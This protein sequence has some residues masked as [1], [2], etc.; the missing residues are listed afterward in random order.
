M[1]DRLP[2]GG[3]DS[4]SPPSIRPPFSSNTSGIVPSNTPVAEMLT[5]PSRWMNSARF[6]PFDFEHEAAGFSG[7]D[8]EIERPL[9]V[10]VPPMNGQVRP[11]PPAARR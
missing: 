9:A 3:L 6:E 11:R 4:S 10:S 8:V 5:S 2:P 7:A 1:Y